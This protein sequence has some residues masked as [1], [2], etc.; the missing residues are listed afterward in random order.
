MMGLVLTRA[1]VES[2]WAAWKVKHGIAQKNSKNPR[3][4]ALKQQKCCV[5]CPQH[6]WG[7]RVSRKSVICSISCKLEISSRYIKDL[8]IYDIPISKQSGT[9]WCYQLRKLESVWSQLWA[10]L[11]WPLHLTSC[12]NERI[13]TLSLSCTADRVFEVPALLSRRFNDTKISR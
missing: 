5:V 2:F 8:A 13:I 1:G 9:W 4:V 6:F 11:A 7:S 3:D 10:R 12:R